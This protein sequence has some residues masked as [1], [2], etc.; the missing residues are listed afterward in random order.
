VKIRLYTNDDRFAWNHFVV[1]SKNT[2]FMFQ[3]DYM[4]YHSSRFDDFSLMASDDN[5]TLLAILPANLHNKTLYSHQGLT[6]GGL[7]THRSVTTNMVCEIFRNI[8]KFLKDTN[9]I[10]NLVY[11]RLPDFYATYPS[12]EDLY[13]LFL[14]DAKLFRRDV[15]VAIDMENP[16]PVSSMR[17]RRIKKAQNLG[18]CVEEVTSLSA[19]WE[20]L[21]EVLT[22]HHG[23]KPVHSASEIQRLRNI[24][25][26][27]IKCFIAKKD[28]KIIAGTLIYETANV[29]HTQYLANSTLGREVGGL[30]IIISELIKNY[31][32]SK[33]YFD[34][35]ISTEDS[36]RTLNSGLISQKEGFGAR[37]FV[38]DFY[39][40]QVN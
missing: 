22:E 33:K 7:C 5:D 13:A 23:I 3:R 37:A 18:V 8:I 40:L 6:F 29:A 17:S 38:H 14:L 35:G 27:N 36:G 28:H 30:D 15:S 2:H 32:T 12:Q 16:L 39:S 1:N 19:Y 9:L 4:E 31:Y 34:F 20:L 25:P 10:E 26:N 11:K 24:F 21:E